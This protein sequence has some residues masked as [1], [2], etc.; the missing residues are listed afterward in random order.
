MP[1]K[2][3]KKR[4]TKK[5]KKQKKQADDRL[6]KLPIHILH[7][8]LCS[9]SQREAVKTCVLSKQW[10]H[11]GSTR[12]NLEFSFGNTQEKYVP[13]DR[14]LQEYYDQNLSINKLHLDLSSP[15]S[16]PVISLLDK[17]IPTTPALNMKVFK[18][19]LLSYTQDLPS[20]VFLAESLEELHL[21]KCRVSPVVESVRL[22]SLHTLSL[23]KVQVDG[24]TLETIMLGCPW[25]SSLLLNRCREL[26]NVRLKSSRLKQLELSDSKRMK[27]CSIDIDVPN[28][29]TVYIN[30]PRIWCHRKRAFAFS[31][32]TSLYF[33]NVILSNESFD[34]LSSGCSN[35]ARLA[36]ENCSGFEEFHLASD[37]V[38]FLRIWTPEVLLKGVRICAPNIVSFQFIA[39]ISQAPDTFSFTTTT[40]KKW[41]SKV[42][43]SSHK[44][45][46]DLDFNSWLLKLR[47]VLKALSGSRISLFLQMDVGLQDE[48]CSAVIGDEPPVVVHTLKFGTCKYRMAAWYMGF[49]NGLFRVCRPSYIGSS[50]LVNKS[51]G[52]CG[53]SEFQLNILLEKR[54]VRTKPYFW[55]H[56]LEQVSVGTL[57][58]RQWRLIRWTKLEVLKKRTQDKKTCFILKWRS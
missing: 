41:S 9:L 15:D 25:L 28:L 44:D 1:R 3:Q 10:R 20:A 29:E 6:S 32:L 8:I 23:K 58:G 42:F 11:I 4:C 35:L 21:R 55:Q 33:C 40:S 26:R 38:K 46:P 54:K 22:K 27:G 16:R 39:R 5:K 30:G 48:P 18:L 57:D 47:R 52:N 13:V 19:N 12:P 37:S 45:D 31:V 49:M 51:D 56:D 36:L 17:W 2:K 34:L 50:R 14:I 53:L 7:H 24:G 43:F